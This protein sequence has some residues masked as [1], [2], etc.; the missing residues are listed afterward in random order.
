MRCNRGWLSVRP[1]AMRIAGLTVGV[2]AVGVVAVVLA[3]CT[4]EVPR[5]LPGPVTVSASSTGAP[6]TGAPSTVSALSTRSAGPSTTGPGSDAAST[7]AADLAALRVSLPTGPVPADGPGPDANRMLWVTY[8]P[9]FFCEGSPVDSPAVVV[10]DDFSVL[11]TDG[12]TCQKQKLPTITTG[13]IDPKLVVGWIDDYLAADLGTLRVIS[14]LV[15][16]GGFTY[17]HLQTP[18]TRQF[19]A[20][21]T[22]AESGTPAR[23]EDRRRLEVMLRILDGLRSNFV[24]TGTIEAEQL[25]VAMTSEYLEKPEAGTKIPVLPSTR[26][27]LSCWAL[28]NEK[29]TVTLARHGDRPAAALWKVDGEVLGLDLGVVLPGFP[30]C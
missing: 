3:A 23:G 1:G 29:V 6:S 2:V 17:L 7:R 21:F 28:P 12:G 15:S 13:R 19:V 27:L 4:A 5:G 8:G 11:T 14:S 26:P 18:S 24:P 22:Q 30:H 9:N 25:V 10:Y 20:G 16:D